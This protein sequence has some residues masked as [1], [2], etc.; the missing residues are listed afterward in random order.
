MLE[1]CI[2]S[3]VLI[4]RSELRIKQTERLTKKVRLPIQIVI[5]RFE[6]NRHN[7]GV[8]WVSPKIVA[9]RQSKWATTMMIIS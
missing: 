3:K 8:K 6:S 9:G 1:I 7:F 4:S 2:H 5:S